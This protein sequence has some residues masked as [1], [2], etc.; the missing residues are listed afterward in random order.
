MTRCWCVLQVQPGI[1]GLSAVLLQPAGTAAWAQYQL[2]HQRPGHKARQRPLRS[3]GYS[4]TVWW[5][6]L[7]SERSL[8]FNLMIQIISCQIHTS[9]LLKKVFCYFNDTN[10]N[11]GRFHDRIIYMDIYFVFRWGVAVPLWSMSV[12]MNTSCTITSSPNTQVF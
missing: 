11:F 12:R 10:L 5:K 1:S 4:V 6:F 3:G 9:T 8:L 7:H 2:H